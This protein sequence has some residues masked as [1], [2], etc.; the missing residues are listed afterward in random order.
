MDG[1]H[2]E[3]LLFFYVVAIVDFG[4]LKSE[5]WQV[6]FRFNCL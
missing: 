5:V 4:Y 6:N 1:G 3:L 2:S